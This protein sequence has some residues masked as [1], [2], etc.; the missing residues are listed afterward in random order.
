MDEK[1]VA[2]DS[3]QETT[4]MILRKIKEEWPEVTTESG[5]AYKSGP[6]TIKILQNILDNIS[7]DD[8]LKGLIVDS[9][10]VEVAACLDMIAQQN[11]RRVSVHDWGGR[12][13]PR[14]GVKLNFPCSDPAEG[15]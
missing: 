10:L 13:Y 7:I 15:K 5:A 4:R 6:V 12:I 14:V 11:S 3:D 1:I 2:S 8:F 9:D